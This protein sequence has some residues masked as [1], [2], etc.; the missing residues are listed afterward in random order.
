MDISKALREC[1]LFKR[2]TPEEVLQ[3]AGFEL[4]GDGVDRHYVGRTDCRSKKEV[5]LIRKALADLKICCS[6]YTDTPSTPGAKEEALIALVC[7]YL[8][9]SG[10]NS[11]SNPHFD[12]LKL[13][14]QQPIPVAVNRPSGKARPAAGVA[15][16]T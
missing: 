4:I 8:D 2:T 3:G 13:A 5:S 9:V 6:E 14:L 12:A 16:H 7:Y 1:K 10:L 11:R 15:A